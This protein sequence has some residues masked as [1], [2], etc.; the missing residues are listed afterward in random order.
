MRLLA[1]NQKGVASSI[2]PVGAYLLVRFCWRMERQENRSGHNEFVYSFVRQSTFMNYYSYFSL[3]LRRVNK[4]PFDEPV[5]THHRR[6][7]RCIRS[8][9]RRIT[10]LS[11]VTKINYRITVR[12]EIAEF[13]NLKNG[14]III[15]VGRT[16]LDPCN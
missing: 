4:G 6:T 9:C 7:T 5:M 11:R 1:F 8:P 12:K 3:F 14:I 16:V 13:L 10:I 2:H 15:I